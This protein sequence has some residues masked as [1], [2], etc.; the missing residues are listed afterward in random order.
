MKF[1]NASEILFPDDIFTG[2]IHVLGIEKK[3]RKVA[4]HDYKAS[5]DVT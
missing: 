3:T 5:L 4:W 2:V 1:P